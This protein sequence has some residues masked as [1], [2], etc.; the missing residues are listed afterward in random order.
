MFDGSSINTLNITS[1]NTDKVTDIGAMFAETP[2]TEIDLM[3]G[4]EIVDLVVERDKLYRQIQTG[5]NSEEMIKK[6][7]NIELQ[8][9]LKLADYKL[10]GKPKG[11][12]IE[13]GYV[14]LD[15]GTD[16]DDFY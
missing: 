14:Y 3:F 11:Y 2:L 16:D 5:I 9:T 8:L 15:D 1:F 10:Y 12:E 7:N 4:K 13:N 6:Y